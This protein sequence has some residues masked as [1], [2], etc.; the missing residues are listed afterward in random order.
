MR[1][2]CHSA[3]IEY[4]EVPKVA[5][6][7]IKEAILR[8]D[9]IDPPSR[10]TTVYSHPHWR[11]RASEKP[12]F[13][14][15]FVRH[16]L[17]RLV[18]CYKQKIPTGK[19]AVGLNCP[20]PTDTSFY[21]FVRWAVSQEIPNKHFAPQSFVLGYQRLDFV[22][23]FD[24]LAEDWATLRSQF[25]QLPE[26]QHFN[27]TQPDDWGSYYDSETRRVAREFY[28]LDFLRWPEFAVD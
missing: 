26:L 25:P 6:T 23:R 15:T 5:C 2:I 16:P 27:R 18:S 22:G 4:I 17:D 8:A 20:L 3:M 7:S 13:A 11:C 21:D 28:L 10:P 12:G 19:G 9:G 14:F 1:Y 24:R